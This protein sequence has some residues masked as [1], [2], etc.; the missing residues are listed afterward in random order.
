VPR[1]VPAAVATQLYALAAQGG[2]AKKDFSSLFEF[3]TTK[4]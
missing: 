3:L 4:N 1:P 2:F